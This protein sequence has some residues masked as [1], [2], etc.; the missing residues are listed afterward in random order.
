MIDRAVVKHV[1]LPL[2]LDTRPGWPLQNSQPHSS[3]KATDSEAIRNG[4]NFMKTVLPGSSSVL[5]LIPKTTFHFARL[6]ARLFQAALLIV[7]GF[8]SVSHAASSRAPVLL[9]NA[10]S[11]RA[12]VLE[13][14]TLKSE[15]FG[16]ISS[17][18]FGPDTRTRLC[19]FAMG[20]DLLPS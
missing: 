6:A 1:I 3:S 8:V 19:I 17:V 4:A 2:N 7:A 15:P 10:T 16:V 12:I 9:S 13:S 11:T 5:S 18:P 20:L 14:I